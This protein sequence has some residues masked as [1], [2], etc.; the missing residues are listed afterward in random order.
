MDH[1]IAHGVPGR[2]G[3]TSFLT[4]RQREIFELIVLGN[5]QQEDCPG[6]RSEP[7]HGENYI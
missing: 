4:P 5:L 3:A 2:F 6:A 1:A 7:G